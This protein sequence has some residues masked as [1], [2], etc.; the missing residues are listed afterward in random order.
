[1]EVLSSHV[2]LDAALFVTCL[3]FESRFCGKSGQGSDL[4]PISPASPQLASY[5]GHA[6]QPFI[7]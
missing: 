4:L 3:N 6:A 1:V 2:A 5:L 7:Y